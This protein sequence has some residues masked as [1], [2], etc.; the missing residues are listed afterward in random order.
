MKIH[1]PNSAFIGN[2]DP[3]I[4]GLDTTDPS[5]LEITT[6]DQWIAV[7]PV[8][9]CILAALGQKVDNVTIDEVTAASGHYMTRMGLYDFL[10]LPAPKKIEEHDSAG[11][12][13]PLTKISTSTELSNFLNE[14]VPMLHLPP[15]QSRSIRYIMSELVRNVLEHAFSPDGAIVAAQYYKKSNTIRIGIVDSGVGIKNSMAQT[16]HPDT[17]LTAIKY[18]L[19]P[20]VTGTTL[21]EGG[22]D[23]NAGAGLFFIKSIASINEDLFLIYSGSSMFKLL[24]NKKKKLNWNPDKDKH[25]EKQD[26]P[27]W[28]GT[29]V[30]ID[31]NL[32]SREAFTSLLELIQGTY[33]EAVRERRKERYKKARFI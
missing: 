24:K 4:A 30:G 23:F 31:I 10:G 27:V 33:H 14:M 9:L 12:F 25:S 18:A 17:D 1:I 13:I 28:Q 19:M 15:E 29:V 22:T 11:R 20:G 16:Y 7:H 32:D 6:N 8:V 26:L 2:I 21:R 3:F 5:I